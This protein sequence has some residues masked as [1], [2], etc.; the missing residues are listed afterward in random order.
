MAADAAPAAGEEVVEVEAAPVP[1]EEAEVLEVE[2]E[3]VEVAA[4]AA[5]AG[6]TPRPYPQTA[7]EGGGRAVADGGGRGGEPRP[8]TND[9]GDW[10]EYGPEGEGLKDAWY[11][12][13]VV[14][15]M[16]DKA[17]VRIPA[18]GEDSEV[19]SRAQ[20]RPLPPTAPDGWA[21]WLQIDDPVDLYYDGGWW[22]VQLVK[23]PSAD[24]AAA[25]DAAGL[26]ANIADGY[27]VRSP[28]YGDEHTV[29]TERL[30][31]RWRHTMKKTYVKPLQPSDEGAPSAAD[32][33]A[34]VVAVQADDERRRR[35]GGGAA[36]TSPS[37]RSLMMTPTRWWRCRRRSRGR[38]RRR[39]I[40]CGRGRGRAVAGRW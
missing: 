11:P 33:D 1:D 16:R 14:K 25:A 17:E 20:L 38:R 13:C 31:P 10:V 26:G 37:T 9:V 24:A 22:E 3:E 36:V 7:A 30:R 40:R 28:R 21:R 6:E 15:V 23:L 32:D 35:A 34:V 29:G 2:V 18:L 4:E 19:A 27:G 39:P 8:F 12:A 5:E